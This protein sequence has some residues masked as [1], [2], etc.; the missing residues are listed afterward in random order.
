MHE[1]MHGTARFLLLTS[2]PVYRAYKGVAD[3]NYKF[4][5]V[6]VAASGDLGTAQSFDFTVDTTAPSVAN[7]TF[8]G[9][10]ASHT[11]LLLRSRLAVH[12]FCL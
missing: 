11:L 9:L 3:G 12:S 4:Q 10:C 7:L 8:S 6:A 1:S 2:P 5:V